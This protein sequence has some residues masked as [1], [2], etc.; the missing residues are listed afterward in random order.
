[1]KLNSFQSIFFVL[2]LLTSISNSAQQSYTDSIFATE[3]KVST[4]HFINSVLDIPYDEAVK[5]IS[6]FQT[7][8][9]L[10]IEKSTR[11][12]DSSLLAK[13]YIQKTLALHFTTKDEEAIKLTL[14]AITIFE[15]LNDTENAAKSYIGLGWKI[16]Y[17]KLNN[18]F[19]YIQK[20][21]KTIKKTNSNLESISA[22][23][24]HLGVLYQM[25]NKLDSALYFH[26]KSLEITTSLNDS[27]G[28]PFAHT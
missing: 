7:L 2:L 21:I 28:I 22:A 18:A 27:I 17:R 19:Y 13:S 12:K 8:T 9:D 5:N 14:K 1:M 16:K 10:A 25:K 26:K 11:L 6:V 3:K 23:Y 4:L 24:N 20:G 15:A